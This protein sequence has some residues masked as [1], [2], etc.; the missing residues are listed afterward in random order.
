MTAKV[1]EDRREKNSFATVVLLSDG[2]DHHLHG[3]TTD[4]S[5]SYP[6]VTSSRLGRYLGPRRR[7]RGRWRSGGGSGGDLRKTPRSATKSNGARHDAT[8]RVRLRLRPDADH[9]RVLPHRTSAVGY[10]VGSRPAGRP[11]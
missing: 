9:G 8:A 3:N 7:L 10:W 2:H 6:V 1:L 5:R 11:L 4:Q